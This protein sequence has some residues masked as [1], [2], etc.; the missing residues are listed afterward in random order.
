MRLDNFLNKA[1]NVSRSEASKII[2]N[3]H[4]KKAGALSPG[5][6]LFFQAVPAYLLLE[7]PV[8]LIL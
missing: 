6:F 3:K 2:K 4:K 8:Y 5:S 1:L 7:Y